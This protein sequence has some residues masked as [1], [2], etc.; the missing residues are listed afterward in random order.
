MAF[1]SNC[2]TKLP[3]GVKFC[4]ECGTR[5]VASAAPAPAAEAPAAEQPILREE[6]V[7]A[8]EPAPAAAESVPVAEESAPAVEETAPAA[9]PAAAEVV[10]ASPAPKKAPKAPKKGIAKFLPFI[11]I[12]AVALLAILIG[13]IVL[14][15]SIFKGLGG[16]GNEEI[17]PN[18]GL[19]N[20]VTAEM[21]GIEM[22]VED[23]WEGG[24]S[25]ELQEDGA[26]VLTVD[27]SAD[28]AE[29][30][31]EDGA[32][33]LSGS[34]AECT[35]TLEDGQIVLDKVMGVD[36]T[37]TF[38]KDGAAIDAPDAP[39]EL[40]AGDEADSAL[41]EQWNG[42]WFG[43]VHVMD[44][45]GKY[46][47]YCDVNMDAF[48]RIDVDK[49]GKGVMRVYLGTDENLPAFASAEIQAADYG[50]DAVSGK[51]LAND[52][53]TDWW[54]FRPVPDYEDCYVISDF[55]GDEDGDTCE[56]L[57]Y[58]KKWDHSW[59]DEIDGG[60]TFIPRSVSYHQM[61][62][63]NGMDAPVISENT[64]VASTL[65]EAAGSPLDT[66]AAAP[67]KE[68]AMPSNWYGWVEFS[69]WWGNDETDSLIDAWGSADIDSNYGDTPYFEVYV[70]NVDT[71]FYSVY[72]TLENDATVIRPMADGYSWVGDVFLEP[73]Q[74]DDFCLYLMGDGTLCA[75]FAFVGA[76]GEYGCDVMMCF[77]EHGQL[78]DEYE[79][80]L[81]PRYDEYVELLEH[82]SALEVLETKPEGDGILSFDEL[83]EGFKV[84]YDS[85][86]GISYAEVREIFGGVEGAPGTWE[87]DFHAYR[88][89]TADGEHSVAVSFNVDENGLETYSGISWS[90]DVG[91]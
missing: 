15:V 67:V 68:I 28:S 39:A 60:L 19:Y 20:A 91:E 12:G 58:M 44:G 1:C 73:G 4:P 81:P 26:A 85:D 90:G 2:G 29:W 3:E 70:D 88:W 55:I 37:L 82:E 6:P 56:Y 79:D 63:D 46:V 54:M 53:D 72:M 71:A 23:I 13:V 30:T 83:N 48:I 27:G 7:V 66:E 14:V 89:Q 34:G 32:F 35:G 9:Q 64:S 22:N 21:M 31:L 86:F 16:K 62:L 77:R 43:G 51:V 33:T 49:E 40:P 45:T 10:D 42:L 74:E 78:W 38:V 47:D 8:A 52:M 24:F 69:N 75:E 84:L 57:L 5:T 36:M 25:I 59:Q 87:S 17:D 65:N 11:I 61:C 41:Q 76:N 80:R 50:I 18:L